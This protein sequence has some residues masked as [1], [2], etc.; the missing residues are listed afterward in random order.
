MSGMYLFAKLVA[1]NLYKQHS[2]AGFEA[3]IDPEISR[4]FRSSVRVTIAF[5]MVKL[6]I[7]SYGSIIERLLGPTIR[8]QTRVSSV[9]K[10]LGWL[11]C[12]KRRL[13]WY[14]IQGAVAVDLN[15]GMIS[16]KHRFREDCKDLCASLM[17]IG[18]EQSVTL[19]HATTKG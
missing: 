13:K 6:N 11:T 3:E 8:P 9:W 15:Q 19:V 14:E 12:A 1:L 18:S 4:W 5:K 16:A 7:S 2:R 10:L 17:E